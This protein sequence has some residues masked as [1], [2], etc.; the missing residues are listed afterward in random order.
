MARADLAAAVGR[1]VAPVA[2]G[3]RHA[4]RAARQERAGRELERA[5]VA[6][7]RGRVDRA[8][9]ELGDLAAAAHDH[10]RVPLV[11]RRPQVAV[12]VE[13]DAVHA[14]Q[15]GVLDEH[16]VEAQRF[17]R[18]RR[19][20]AG[21][22]SDVAATVELDLPDG[23]AG[24][25]R[26]V[27]VAVGVKATPFATS[28]CEPAVLAALR[29]VGVTAIVPGGSER[30]SRAPPPT[31]AWRLTSLAMG[32]MRN[33]SVPAPPV[34]PIRHTRPCPVVPSPVHAPAPVT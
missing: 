31:P 33:T 16:C 23:A 32:W 12:P 30:T 15:V 13:R 29:L 6:E 8:P 3:L 4:E 34:G 22:D 5:L 20:A 11:G 28:A 2:V 24:R 18:E 26:H 1:V 19:V 27:E 21:R 7:L 14:L 17:G 10:D 9:E 25:V